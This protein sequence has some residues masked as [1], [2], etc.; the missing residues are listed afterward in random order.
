MPSG[1][2]LGSGDPPEGHAP[3]FHKIGP[4]LNR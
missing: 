2:R 4:A 3:T 1:G